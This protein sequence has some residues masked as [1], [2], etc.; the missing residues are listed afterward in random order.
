MVHF[1]LYF[2]M[3]VL[4]FLLLLCQEWA[5]KS[6]F[7]SCLFMGFSLFRFSCYNQACGW[8]FNL[9][10]Y[11]LSSSFSFLGVVATVACEFLHPNW[12]WQSLFHFFDN[13]FSII[14]VLYFS[15]PHMA[16]FEN[17]VK[18]N[19]KLSEISPVLSL[20]NRHLLRYILRPRNYFHKKQTR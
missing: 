14:H 4:L 16:L 18:P 13:F 7:S 3:S 12:K 19:K 9:W 1:S 2:S 17:Y 11:S 10:F 5:V 15:P 20:L 6:V 8:F